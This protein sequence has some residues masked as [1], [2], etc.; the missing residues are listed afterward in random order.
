MDPKCIICGEEA[1]FDV[2]NHLYKEHWQAWFD[3]KIEVPNLLEESP[4]SE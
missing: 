2:P 1:E 3:Y 4:D